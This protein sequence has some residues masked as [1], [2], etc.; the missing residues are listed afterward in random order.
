[1]EYMD[2]CLSKIE[3]SEKIDLNKEKSRD[4]YYLEL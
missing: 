3:E 4:D 2:I 1:M